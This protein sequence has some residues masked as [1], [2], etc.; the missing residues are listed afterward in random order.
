[1]SRLLWIAGWF[2]VA[3]WSLFS[4][5]AYGVVDLLGAAFVRNSDLFSSDP[6]TVVAISNVL[7]W[8]RSFS[9]GAILVIWGI[10]SL[11]ILSVPFLFDR[12]VGKAPAPLAM[13]QARA[14]RG[15]ID[16]APGDYQVRDPGP[17]RPGTVPRVGPRP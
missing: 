13:A 8:M 9:G 14:P 16:L 15:V 12:L 6:E 7:I 11:L 2:G 10:V 1:M 5:A 4:F 17:P 3:V